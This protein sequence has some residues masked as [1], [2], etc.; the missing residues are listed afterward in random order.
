MY[1]INDPLGQTHSPASSDHYKSHLNFVL[2]CENFKSGTY[3]Q[4]DNT[5]KIV[6]TTGR[7]CWS[8]SWIKLPLKCPHCLN[9]RCVDYIAR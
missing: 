5:C 2:F 3:G 7:D 1:V 8:A 9:C 4:T 6:I